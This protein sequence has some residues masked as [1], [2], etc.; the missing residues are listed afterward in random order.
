MDRYAQNPDARPR[1]GGGFFH[2][3]SAELEEEDFDSF[4][5]PEESEETAQDVMTAEIYSVAVDAGLREI[6][7]EMAKHRIH[8]VLVQQD[9][10]YVG[11]ISTME[12]I[13]SLSA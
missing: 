9:G 3:S 2:L 5:V 8:R 12:I 13:D 7:V 6:A 4:D 10:R 11:L 1:R